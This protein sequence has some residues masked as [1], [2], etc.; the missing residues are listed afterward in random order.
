MVTFDNIYSNPTPPKNKE[1]VSSTLNGRTVVAPFHGAI[2]TRNSGPV[3]YRT[4]DILNSWS[5]MKEEAGLIMYIEGIVNKFANVTEFETSFMLI[6]TW[7]DTRCA[8]DDFD[9]ARVCI[10]FN[11]LKILNVICHSI[12]CC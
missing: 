9:D 3:Y 6:A 1:S 7:T 12:L 5:R 2:D 8:R 4:Y 10:N 11:I